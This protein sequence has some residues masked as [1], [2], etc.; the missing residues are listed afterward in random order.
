MSNFKC[1]RLLF[2]EWITDIKDMFSVVHST[3]KDLWKNLNILGR[4]ICLPILAL[5]LCLFFIVMS[6]GILIVFLILFMATFCF[7][8]F[9]FCFLKRKRW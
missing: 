5:I 6:C 7:E 1:V 8:L 2:R 4:V 9:Q 3:I